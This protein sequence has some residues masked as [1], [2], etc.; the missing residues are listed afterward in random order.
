MAFHRQGNSQL[1]YGVNG[2]IRRNS[3]AGEDNTLQFLSQ[4]EQECIQF[5]EDTID[6][7]EESLVGDDQR[8]SLVNLPDSSS[9]PLDKVNGLPTSKPNLGVNVPSQHDIID[10]VHPEPDLVHTKEPVFNPS[11]PDFQRMLPTPESHFEVKPRR[12]SLPSEYNPPLPSGSY[13]SADSHSSYHP[14]GCIPTPVLIAQKIAEN[15]G[16]GTSNLHP[17]SILRRLSLES[18]KP[19]SDSTDTPVKQGP[20]TSAK[21]TRFPPNIS[22]I[23]GNKEHQKQP[24]AN[25]NIHERRDQMLANLSGTSH[26][27]LL[28]H[29]QQTVEQKARN[30]PTRSISFKD[31]SPDKS[32][33]E[34]LSK[35]GLNRNQTVSGE[36]AQN[37]TTVD[38][39]KAP[40]TH[41]K[42]SETS[43]PQLMQSGT[44]FPESSAVTSPPSHLHVDRKPEILQTHSLKS[45]DDRSSQLSPSSPTLT[46][47]RHYPP[48]QE[49]KASVP[50][51]AEVTSLEF[52]SYGGKSII[53]NPSVSSRSEPV[54]SPT[55]QDLKTLPPALS[56][57]T[58][59]NTYGGKSK[60]MTLAP[61]PMTTA[62]L[63]DIL[64]SH[65]DKSQTMPAKPEP[66]PSELNSY[67]GKSRSFNPAT[68]FNLASGSPAKS[69][70][71]P[72]TTPV[73][74]IV[75]QSYHGALN[76]KTG[77]RAISPDRR[78]RSNSMFRPQGIT[79]QFS[80]R[81]EM[82]ESRRE[83]LRK[84]GLLKDS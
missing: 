22:V 5:F 25:V 8:S 23:L 53:V 3:R 41:S 10:L 77:L 70:K 55:S 50:P 58:E 67:G 74:R 72:A 24:G 49:N 76:Q 26:P 81:G 45:H 65:I 34:A 71:A 40:D 48:P 46:Q 30:T 28:E 63:P 84:L 80:G 2:G 62:N 16:G 39:R 57:P 15:Q 64:S 38:S 31:P 27:L 66:L 83:A 42:S 79:V 47:N 12:D 59:L 18:E 52:N 29:S 73:P 61:A 20:P 36:V 56:N 11:N 60:V 13:G 43:L 4:E 37:S 44:N 7:L 82:N 32:R 17:S 35:L 54:S 33:M 14:P 1:H 69:I 78:R 6:S 9:I 51:P 19:P 75:R 68:G 21:P